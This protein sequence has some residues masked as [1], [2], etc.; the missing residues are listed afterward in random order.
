MDILEIG[1]RGAKEYWPD[2]EITRAENP[3]ELS[4]QY[5]VIL[6]THW[7]QRVPRYEV[8]DLLKHWRDHL[9]EDGMLYIIA[10]DLLWIAETIKQE[11]DANPVVLA[12]LYGN[13]DEEHY[14]AFTMGMLRDL[15]QLSG[16]VTQEARR[17]PF[18]MG[19]GENET[20]ARQLFVRASK[21]TL[22]APESMVE[23]P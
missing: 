19:V 16:F 17:G 14:C 1:L 4:D 12:A 7:L 18:T 6:C 15:M 22:D 13:Q 9:T 10:T 8:V 21:A 5:D 2:G 11:R 23:V 20:M 3:R